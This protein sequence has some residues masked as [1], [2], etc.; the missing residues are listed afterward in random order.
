MLRV[1]FFIGVVLSVSIV[2]LF[3]VCWF[4]FMILRMVNFIVS[5][6]IVIDFLVM[7]KGR[8]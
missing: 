4:M 1:S 8:D 6:I 5:Y 7:Y 3:C 2:L